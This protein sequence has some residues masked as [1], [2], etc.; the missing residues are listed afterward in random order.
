M[1]RKNQFNGIKI[2]IRSAASRDVA[3]IDITGEIGVANEN[4]DWNTALA[5][6][7][8]LREIANMN[9]EKIIV[10]INSLGGFVDDGLAI[11]DVLAMHPAKI[12][13]RVIGMCASAATVIAQAGDVRH[14]SENALYLIHR[15]WG[16]VMG[17]VHQLREIAETLRQIDGRMA[18][19]YA[20]RSG[21]THKKMLEV[22][23]ENQGGGI[24][25]SSD[26]AIAI[27]LIDQVFK[28]TETAGILDQYQGILRDPAI[29]AISKIAALRKINAHRKRKNT[30]EITH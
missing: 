11:H 10:N 7:T 29:P 24:W 14:M 28:P 20:K 13:T 27:G 9:A 12:E 18:E 6:K 30:N 5:I 16:L 8:K 15:A 4:G 1:N 3:I 23:S 21:S 2:N 19:I 25:L 22:M 26:E 17:N